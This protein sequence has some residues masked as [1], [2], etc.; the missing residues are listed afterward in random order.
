MSDEENRV[1]IRHEKKPEIK[2]LDMDPEF[3]DKIFEQPSMGAEEENRV[4]LK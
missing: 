4:I 1:T 3:F 2:K